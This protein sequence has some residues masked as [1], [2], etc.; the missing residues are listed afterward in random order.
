M[1]MAPFCMTWVMLVMVLL[2]LLRPA[3]C[4]TAWWA[5]AHGPLQ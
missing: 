5:H 1:A 4:C 2:L 3:C